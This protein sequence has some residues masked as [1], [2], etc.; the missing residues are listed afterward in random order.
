MDFDLSADQ[1]ALPLRDAAKA[2]LDDRCDMTTVR[3]ACDRGGFDAGLWQAMV[4]RGWTGLAVPEPLGGVGLGTVEAAVLLEQ[5]GAHA[6][7]HRARL[8]AV[9]RDRVESGAGIWPDQ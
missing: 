2:L 3:R 6:R 5:T 9:L 8:A 7:H 4:D 1:L